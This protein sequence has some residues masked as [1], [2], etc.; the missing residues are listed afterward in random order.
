MNIKNLYIIIATILF[1]AILTK[2]LFIYPDCQCD[3]INYGLLLSTLALAVIA[4]IQLN[5]LKEQANADF[6]LKF[7]REFFGI[8]INQKI[9]Q[10]LE[11][12]NTILEDHDGFINEYQLDD[13]LG[14]YE[15]MAKFEKK[16]L[17][18]FETIDDMFGHYISKS[19]QNE[20]IQNYIRELR[21]ETK[22]PRYYKPFEKLAIRIIREEQKVR[23]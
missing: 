20:E 10:A 6:L 12:G 8:D 17:I 19:W 3:I 2:L 5:A 9:I 16:N 22:D 15:L 11:E 23:S 4:Y 1:I 13:F 21:E 18:D 14:Y 7:N